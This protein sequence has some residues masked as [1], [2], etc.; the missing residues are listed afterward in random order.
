M[1][2]PI[3]P[4]QVSQLAPS[5]A[6]KRSRRGPSLQA[7]IIWLMV[8]GAA[9]VIAVLLLVA[10]SGPAPTEVE[11]AGPSAEPE[12]SA[13]PP[14]KIWV[15]SDAL[16][17]AKTRARAWHED[18]TLVQVS[19][20][21]ARAGLVD[22]SQGGVIEHVFGVPSRVALPGNP[23]GV[24]VYVVRTTV[25]DTS[26]AEVARPGALIA[27]EPTCTGQEAWSKAVAAG[28]NRERPASLEYRHEAREGRGLWLVSQQDEPDADGSAPSA[29]KLTRRV[30]GQSCAIVRR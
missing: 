3:A 17:D 30:D 13:E 16:V 10:Q 29:A 11:L 12:A 9:V 26:A 4:P 20:T 5:V 19:A 15:I 14:P 1:S 24:T 22:L 6:R 18:A 7:M 27:A 28:L 23:V 21:G 8:A 25:E 2:A